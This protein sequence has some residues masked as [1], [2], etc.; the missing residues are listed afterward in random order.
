MTRALFSPLLLALGLLLA[1]PGPAQAQNRFWFVNAGGEQINQLYVSS[2]R[3]Q[4]WGPDILGASVLPPGQR[5][6]VTP[7]FGDCVLDVRAVYASGRQETRMQVNACNLS[8]IAFGGAG[9]TVAPPGA[10]AGATVTP[11]RPPGA[12]PAQGNP[13]FTFVNAS[14]E[15]ISEIYVSLSSQ[16][17][18]GP[19][20]LGAN[21]LPPGQSLAIPLPLG[22]G[23][24]TDI[25]VVY[26]SGR[27]AERR[28]VETCSIANLSWR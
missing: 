12:V 17:S 22:G 24:L 14:G 3:V 4:D 9:A 26:A 1:L 20:R 2:S 6:F 16:S 25:R 21:V 8:Q 7:N 15:Q 13:S 11:G 28:Q 19:D 10:G 23:C 18:Y 27:A 5:V